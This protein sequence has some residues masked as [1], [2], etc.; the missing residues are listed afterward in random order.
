MTGG[1]GLI[2]REVVRHLVRAGA[3][4]RTL[5]RRGRT[6]PAGDLG[7]Q[8]DEV[9][10]DFTDPEVTERALAGV[11][12]VC[13]LAFGAGSTWPE[14]LEQD[15]EP[16]LALVEAAAAA[17]VHRFV[18]ASTIAVYW[19]GRRRGTIDESVAADAGVIRVNPYA[20]GKAEVEQRI[21]GR[22]ALQVVVM[23]PGIVVGPGGSP[24]HWGVGAWPNPNVCALWGSGHDALPFVTA[25]DCGEAIATALTTEHSLAA[26][27]NLVGDVRLTG[28]EYL[29]VVERVGGVSIRRVTNRPARYFAENVAKWG[30][31]RVGGRVSPRPSW[32]DADGRT[33]RASFDNTAAKRDL[34]WSPVSD[35]AEFEGAHLAPMILEW[36]R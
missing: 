1:S 17:G 26:S 28:H 29:D 23:R 32:H 2:G 34:G 11:R 18:F 12:A 24:I 8:V 27:Y 3:S 6:D 9:I 22:A 19:A 25:A 30:L 31:K 33:L 13:H 20:R 15:V 35:R 21:A 7:T 16:T 4:V 10:G 14:V 5:A 36:Y